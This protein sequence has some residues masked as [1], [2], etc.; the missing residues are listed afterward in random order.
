MKVNSVNFYS[1]NQ[2]LKNNSEA[3]R[4]NNAYTSMPLNDITSIYYQP[5]Q[6]NFGMAKF[7]KIKSLNELKELAHLP[8]IYCG[9]EMIS[10]AAFTELDSMLSPVPRSI[11]AFINALSPIKETLTPDEKNIIFRLIKEYQ[12]S[13]TKKL[14]PT[15]ENLGYVIPERLQNLYYDDLSRVQYTKKVL[16]VVQKHK[17]A[18]FPPEKS[19]FETIKKHHEKHPDKS[20][21]EIVQTLRPMY[22][23]F[24]I[25]ENM[26]IIESIEKLVPNL[27]EKNKEVAVELINEAKDSIYNKQGSATFNNKNFVRTFWKMRKDTSDERL[28]GNIIKIAASFPTPETSANA[29]FIRFFP[30]NIKVGEKAKSNG[31]VQQADKDIVQRLMIRSLASVEHI[32]PQNDFYGSPAEMN[33]IENLALAHS[34]CNND[35][36][37]SD[38]SNYVKKHPSLSRYIQKQVDFIIDMINK[39]VLKNCDNYPKSIR[40]AYLSESKGL[41]DIDISKLKI[42]DANNFDSSINYFV[43]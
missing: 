40:A 42:D 43:K 29:F 20:L 10:K 33:S 23:N 13:T 3:K 34:H 22:E 17:D 7:S 28:A 24:L 39:H 26:T 32:K 4:Y 1:K 15:I 12:K 14:I 38:L 2:H 6:I 31:S 35:R 5:H 19:I 25:D 9:K 27:S 11:K 37:H 21:G 8:C 18:L 30:S 41:I 36:A 16:N